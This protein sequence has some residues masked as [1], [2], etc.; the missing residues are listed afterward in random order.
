MRKLFATG[1]VL[2]TVA[3][4]CL[5]AIAAENSKPAKTEEATS[6]ESGDTG[7]RLKQIL[8]QAAKSGYVT[9]GT[10]GTEET[11]AANVADGKRKRSLRGIEAG[12]T[13][14]VYR[15]CPGEDIFQFSEEEDAY[16]YD[17]ILQIKNE[18][19]S[20]KKKYKEE[21]A[22]ALG[23]AY[24][25][26][27]LGEEAAAIDYAVSSE[28]TKLISAMGDVIAGSHEKSDALKTANECAEEA[29]VWYAMSKLDD[30]PDTVLT[31]AETIVPQIKKL[32]EALRQLFATR[33]GII[34]AES[35]DIK[36]ASRLL[37][38][39]EHA[40]DMDDPDL[41]YLKSLLATANDAPDAMLDLQ[42]I[43]MQQGPMQV[44]ALLKIGQISAENGT[45]PYKDYLK[46][47]K[48]TKTHYSGTHSENEAVLLEIQ[49]Q[50]TEGAYGKAISRAKGEFNDKP[51]YLVRS[52]DVIARSI[53]THLK[54]NSTKLRF[55]ALD[56][57]HHNMPFFVGYENLETLKLAAAQTALYFD[58]PVLVETFIGDSPRTEQRDLVMARAEMALNRPDSVLSIASRYKGNT[59][60]HALA[61]DAAMA[62]GKVTLAQQHLDALQQTE[63][64][65]GKKALY[66]WTAGK[67]DV[68]K[69]NYAALEENEQG[70]VKQQY[71]LAAYMGGDKTAFPVLNPVDLSKAQEIK[72]LILDFEEEKDLLKGILND[73]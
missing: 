22:V 57:Y 25:A 21:K 26:L 29:A 72:S 13:K 5:P 11:A 36:L 39:A 60:F 70:T 1:A 30:E 44:K 68:A 48:V 20:P 19:L 38:I 27:A 31:E 46:D 17:K 15:K 42:K 71:A 52:R 62:A 14:P 45:L 9:L 56:A 43:S 6:A 49:F 33:L 51:G 66:A 64:V 16:S 54:G 69:Q 73:G 8:E 4:C 40:G 32:P 23:K 7:E 3:I 28:R 63:E 67:W 34:A 18:L 50:V 2:T 55:S 37:N 24:L 12:S 47:L 59:R 41:A 65:L 58:L 35:N 53:E 61:A 10:E